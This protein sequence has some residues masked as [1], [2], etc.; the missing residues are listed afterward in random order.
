MATDWN[1]Y[2][3][4][5]EEVIEEAVK[6]TSFALPGLPREGAVEEK[7]AGRQDLLSRGLQNIQADH[8]PENPDP[9]RTTAARVVS[10]AVGGLQTLGG[11]F[12]R[13][14]AGIANMHIAAQKH[15]SPETFGYAVD[16]AKNLIDPIG[17]TINKAFKRESGTDMPVED[18]ANLGKK[19]LVSSVEGL[20]GKRL[21][22]FGDPYRKA[23][24]NPVLSEVLG[25]GMGLITLNAALAS[26]P[27]KFL[28][29]RF[30]KSKVEEIANANTQKFGNAVVKVADDIKA[31]YSRIVNPHKGVQT[32]VS[33]DQIE[34]MIPV[35]FRDVLKESIKRYGKAT[36]ETTSSIL[37]PKGK[38]FVKNLTVGQLDDLIDDMSSELNKYTLESVKATGRKPNTGALVEQI[39]KMRDLKIKYLPKD[40]Q[41]AVKAINPTYGKIIPRVEQIK[42]KMGYD[43]KTR[44]FDTKSSG[45]VLSDKWEATLRQHIKDVSAL[46][47]DITKYMKL[48]QKWGQ[49]LSKKSLLSNVGFGAGLGSAL[50]SK[51]VNR[52][53]QFVGQDPQTASPKGI[54]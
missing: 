53:K 44:T 30:N 17:R 1:K 11:V 52:G 10:G 49:G 20:S 25:T 13:G 35:K 4:K 51:L 27:L 23:V 28:N 47:P 42:Y 12:Q 3:A 46:N 16:V 9:Q 5:E 32:K 33:V 38:K 39:N 29:N 14:E 24:K 6:P 26:K 31:D 22:E 41:A 34:Q 40:V 48:V 45:K 43:P 21:G 2:K 50:G 54:E 8:L 19:M 15:M 36:K 37:D 18:M 7:I